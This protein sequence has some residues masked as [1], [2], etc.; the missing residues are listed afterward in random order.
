[1]VMDILGKSLEDLN[2]ECKGKFSLKTV[3]LLGE[4]MIRRI[5]YLHN[6]RFLHRD[7]KPDNFVMGVENR[8]HNVFIIDF[9]LAKRYLRKNG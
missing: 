2:Q 1:M 7:I 9:G 5:Q 8:K 3:L 6:C 4:Q